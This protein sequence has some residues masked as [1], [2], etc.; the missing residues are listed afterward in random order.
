M[1]GGI[2]S[3]EPVLRF[4]SLREAVFEWLNLNR[5]IASDELRRR[6]DS[7]SGRDDAPMVTVSDKDAERVSDDGEPGSGS[8]K[9]NDMLT[10]S[11]RSWSILKDRWRV[12][13][14]GPAIPSVLVLDG[15]G[16]T[17]DDGETDSSVMADETAS[18]VW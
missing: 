3:C 16:F 11:I 2:A 12:K 6:I 14:D 7:M 8:D 4:W 18:S 13:A 10:S 5:G 17:G 15:E 1:T 9:G